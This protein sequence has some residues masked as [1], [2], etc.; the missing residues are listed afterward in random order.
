MNFRIC[1]LVAGLIG[2]QNLKFRHIA[3]KNSAPLEID[4]GSFRGIV[5]YRRVYARADTQ[6][7]IVDTDSALTLPLN[8][9]HFV[10]DISAE[11]TLKFK[12][13]GSYWNGIYITLIGGVGNY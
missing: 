6:A 1:S 4:L 8:G 10:D 11:G 12:G 3:Y 13:S 2:L 5:I 7:W 9:G